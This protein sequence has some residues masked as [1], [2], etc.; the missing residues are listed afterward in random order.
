MALSFHITKPSRGY[1]S[2]YHNIATN[3]HETVRNAVQGICVERPPGQMMLS[4][5]RPDGRFGCLH[6]IDH[7]VGHP[8]SEG[9]A[10]EKGSRSA[11]HDGQGWQGGCA[12]R[13]R[14]QALAEAAVEV[15]ALEGEEHVDGQ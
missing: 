15:D 10:K 8:H 1:L 3:V 11:T 14:R 2:G 5:D 9:P 7:T 12:F 13:C 6:K 4:S